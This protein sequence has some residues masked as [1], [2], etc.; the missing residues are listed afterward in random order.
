MPY[1]QPKIEK[2]FYS[3][4]EVAGMFNVNT[5]KIRYYENKFDIL[6]PRK[7]KKGNRMFTQ[8]DVNNLKTIFYLIEDEGVTI[9]GAIK[10]IKESRKDVVETAEAVNKLKE[11]KKELIKLQDQL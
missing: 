10:K 4:S 9:K 7:N 2:L 3:I 6:K 1:K 11:I 5:S 8:E